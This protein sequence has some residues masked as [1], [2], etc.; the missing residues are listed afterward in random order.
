MVLAEILDAVFRPLARAVDVRRAPRR[1][2]LAQAAGLADPTVDGYG[3]VIARDGALTIVISSGGN[4]RAHIV[5]VNGL[6][7][8]LRIARAGRGSRQRDTPSAGGVEV[9]DPELDPAVVLWLG[10]PGLLSLFDAETR[11]RVRAEFAGTYDLRIAYG[12]LVAR[13]VRPAWGRGDA[14]E[15]T[16]RSL[17]T[18]AHR[19]EAPAEPAVRLG[20]MATGDPLGGVRYRALLT[21]IQLFPQAPGTRD[22]LRVALLDPEAAVRLHAAKAVGEEGKGTLRALAVDPRVDDAVAAEAIDVLGASFAL[23]DARA[24]AASAVG[25]GRVRTA[26]AAFSVV[27]RGGSG[28]VPGVADLLSR[29]DGLVAVAAVRALAAIGGPSVEVPL[30]AALRAPEAVVAAAAAGA[31]VTCGGVASVPDLKTA[32]GRGGDVRRAARQAIAAI[33]ARLTGASPG[34]VSLA[35]AGGEMSVADS[36]DGRVS[37]RS[38]D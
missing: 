6:A 25:A 22:F 16:V 35:S 15:T 5:S 1:M 7:P 2:A 20:R 18:L 3:S 17:V 31:L 10:S 19:L 33:Q 21:L 32:E 8:E 27:G 26:V 9:G 34:Q 11:A 36:A 37:F 4:R 23:A 13:L 29:T 24:V 14:L 30:V 12:E 28:E 38:E